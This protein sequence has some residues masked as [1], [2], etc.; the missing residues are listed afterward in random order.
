MLMLLRFFLQYHYY[1][2]KNSIM[3]SIKNKTVKIKQEKK[4]FF[5]FSTNYIY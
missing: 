3:L 2:K 5:M 1:N 4:D